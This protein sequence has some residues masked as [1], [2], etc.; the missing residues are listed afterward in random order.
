M[1]A[2]WNFLDLNVPLMIISLLSLYLVIN[3]SIIFNLII[4]FETGKFPPGG[5]QAETHR[6]RNC[7][8]SDVGQDQR[9]DR[10]PDGHLQL[11]VA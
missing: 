4:G 6:L 11:H 8:S 5:W 10:Q 1:D 2:N 3:V 9:D 7:F